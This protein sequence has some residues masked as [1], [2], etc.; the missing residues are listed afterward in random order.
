MEV[1]EAGQQAPSLYQ[2][3]LLPEA[4]DAD[5]TLTPREEL[6]LMQRQAVLTLAADQ[7]DAGEY[8]AA[9]SLL[10]QML[11]RAPADE[12]VHRELMRLYS[13][14]GRHHEALRQY[15]ACAEVLAAEFDA[16]PEAETEAL[17]KQILNRS[18]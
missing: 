5:G 11:A 13:L 17:Y 16:A 14:D 6:R 2:G 12:A 8:A 4:R 1:T 15:Q 9:I 10:N 18:L 3:D 7:R